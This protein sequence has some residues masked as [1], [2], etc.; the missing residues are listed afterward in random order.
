V[1]FLTIIAFLGLGANLAACT[2]KSDLGSSPLPAQQAGKVERDWIPDG[3]PALV[4]YSAQGN[5]ARVR[6]LVEKQNVAIDEADR[7]TQKT[8][9]MTAAIGGQLEVMDYLLA[10]GANP[11]AQD[12]FR[13]T[14]LDKI[15]QDKSSEVVGYLVSPEKDLAIFKAFVSAPKTD[16]YKLN[17]YKMSYL[18]R[19]IRADQNI[20]DG[21]ASYVSALLDAN[22]DISK[23]EKGGY[24]FL[25]AVVEEFVNRYDQSRLAWG[26]SS[27]ILNDRFLDTTYALTHELIQAG[28]NSSPSILAAASR[29]RHHSA[30][31]LLR[32]LR[33]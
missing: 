23:L 10:H 33:T 22:F 27:K 7:L 19:A 11:N 18:E 15:L 17:D 12:Q 32:L 16:L 28:A 25:N 4:F 5:L 1:D 8:A 29:V 31:R 30:D 14:V 24:P 20:S 3:V 21:S 9:L 13:Q 6:N 2:P 26:Q